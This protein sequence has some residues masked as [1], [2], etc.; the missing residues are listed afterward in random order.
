[1][2]EDFHCIHVGSGFIVGALRNNTGN[3]AGMRIREARMRNQ[4]FF[5]ECTFLPEKPGRKQKMEG[6]LVDMCGALFAELIGVG[7]LA[8]VLYVYWKA[9]SSKAGN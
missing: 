3:I 5:P 7:L 2:S 9:V 4:T 1:M 8:G 6:I